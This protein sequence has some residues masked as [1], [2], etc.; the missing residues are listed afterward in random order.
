MDLVYSGELLLNLRELFSDQPS[1]LCQKKLILGGMIKLVRETTDVPCAFGFGIA[2]PEQAEYVA[3]YS[4]GAIAG[5]A[6]V[7]IVAKYGKDCL[8]YINEYVKSMKEAVMKAN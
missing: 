7:K 5:S 2:T 6:I 4:D 1:L 3:K 8:P